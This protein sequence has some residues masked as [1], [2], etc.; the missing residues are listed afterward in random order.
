MQNREIGSAENKMGVMPIFP[1]IM[2]MSLPIMFSMFIIALYF[3]VDGMFV[4]RIS[5]D[6]FAAITLTFPA[7]NIINAFAV[8]TGV[9][10]SSFLSRMLGAGEQRRVDKTAMNALFLI[11]CTYILFIVLSRVFLPYF[12]EAQKVSRVIKQ[13]A[14]EYMDI[15]MLLSFGMFFGVIL[16]RLLQATGLTIYTMYSQIAGAVFNIL[17]DPVLIFGFGPIPKMGIKGAAYATVGG[18]IFG[19]CVSIWANKARNHFISF[20]LRN[21]VPDFT[22]IKEIYRVGVPSILL[23][24]VISL[25]SYFMNMILSGFSSVAIAA[26]GVYFTLN[27]FV[28]MPVFGLNGGLIPIISYNYGAKN[29]LRIELSIKCALKIAFVSMLLGTVIFEIF[30]RELFLLFDASDEMLR[31]GIPLIRIAS[32][33]FLGAAFGIT[34]G[35]VFQAFGKGSYSLVITFIRQIVVLLPLAYLFSLSG[36]INM[37]WWAYLIAELAAVFAGLIFMRRIYCTKISIIPYEE[38]K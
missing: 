15:I 26:F 10:A 18:Q 27:S 3:T 30:P 5:E 6:A 8:G 4:A 13:Y 2:N 17:I 36:D 21:L 37:I 35:A 32:L 28:F 9:G 29:R 38:E 31:I 7:A 20:K 25:V 34:F 16:D 33:S 23:S 22:I 1:L 11:F 12:I 14:H 19:L 24:A